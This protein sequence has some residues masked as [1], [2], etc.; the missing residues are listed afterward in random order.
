MRRNFEL[1][2]ACQRGDHDHVV[3]LLDA[4]NYVDAVGVQ[5]VTPLMAACMCGREKIALL[6]LERGAV[7]N[8]TDF[9]GDTALMRACRNDY[10]A[11]ARLLCSFGALR[12]MA[13]RHGQTAVDDAEQCNAKLAEWLVD[14]WHWTT[15]LHHLEE[16]TPERT[17]ALLADID[18]NARACVDVPF[19][20]P[21]PL[22]RARALEGGG[23]APRGSPAR[24]VLDWWRS[25]LA[26]LAMGTHARLGAE[27]AVLKLAGEVDVFQMIVDFV[28]LAG[29]QPRTV[30]SSSSATTGTSSDAGDDDEA[31][32]RATMASM[33]VS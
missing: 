7:V 13:N 18:P 6:L 2:D 33:A 16:L 17:V 12:S 9:D 27:S 23:K 31:R 28:A 8:T 20:V 24:L 14:S 22:D 29:A 26:A 5:G 30:G 3:Q 1:V 11:I 25:R 10:P 32:L 4:R 19:D 21:S 15:P